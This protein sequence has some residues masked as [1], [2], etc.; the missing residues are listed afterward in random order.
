VCVCARARVDNRGELWQ[1]LTHLLCCLVFA[2][3]I[4]MSAIS[5]ANIHLALLIHVYIHL[6]SVSGTSMIHRSCSRR[7]GRSWPW[8][9]ARAAPP[10]CAPSHTPPTTTTP[11][12]PRAL[13]WTHEIIHVHIMKQMRRSVPCVKCMWH[14][15]CK[16][17]ACRVQRLGELQ[18]SGDLWQNGDL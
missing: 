12:P 1:A 13:T 11:S 4:P 6:K 5:D 17:D 9:P 7:S 15:E 10:R 16:A 2:C 3:L 14:V 8:L 18:Q